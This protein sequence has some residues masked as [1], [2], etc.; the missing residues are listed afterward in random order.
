[1]SGGWKVLYVHGGEAKVIGPKLLLGAPNK[2][3]KVPFIMW[4]IPLILKRKHNRE[5]SL[6]D[7]SQI[8]INFHFRDQNVPNLETFQEVVM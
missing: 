4:V 3:I 1:M 2:K 8:G 5:G 7:R 6:K